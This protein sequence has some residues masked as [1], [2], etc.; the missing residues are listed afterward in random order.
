VHPDICADG[1][2]RR[3]A[4]L[5]RPHLSADDCGQSDVLWRGIVCPECDMQCIR[6][7][8]RVCDMS[9]GRNLRRKHLSELQHLFRVLDMRW[10]DH[11]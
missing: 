5:C 7:L 10:V 6:H 4:D 9:A 3:L 11:V 1:Q 2:L 8:P